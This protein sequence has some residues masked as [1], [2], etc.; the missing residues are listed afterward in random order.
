L[1][2]KIHTTTTL[3]ALGIKTPREQPNSTTGVASQK[4]RGGPLTR[5]CKAERCHSFHLDRERVHTASKGG[6]GGG[7]EVDTV[8][9]DNSYADDDNNVASVGRQKMG[10]SPSNPAD[11]ASNGHLETRS[12]KVPT[13]SGP[14]ATVGT[15]D[16][17]ISSGGMLPIAS[18]DEFA[19]KERGCK[20]NDNEAA[21]AAAFRTRQ[22]A[23]LAGGGPA[24]GARC[25]ADGVFVR[26]I[27]G[28][29]NAVAASAR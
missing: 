4:S 28:N 27:S 12:P 17:D 23:E 11:W 19:S 9:M 25:S 14:S 6:G 22:V 26:A 3:Q 18:N 10:R 21:G 24:A 16:D 13:R 7:A 1:T 15:V 8:V 2:T 5:R 29:D 20:P